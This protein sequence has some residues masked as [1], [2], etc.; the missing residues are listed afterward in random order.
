M[1]NPKK[2]VEVS[3]S[4]QNDN[5]YPRV[6]PRGHATLT[7]KEYISER[8]NPAIEWYDDE[9][10][11]L[12]KRYLFMRAITVIGGALVPVLVNLDIP[13]ID[14]LTT[15]ISLIVVLL[16]SL[17]SVYHYSAQWTN[18]RST[19]Q[20]LRKEY[21]LFVANEGP[22]A[23]NTD[24]VAYRL[25]VER[26]EMAIEAEVSTTLRVMTTVSET[27]SEGSIPQTASGQP[28]QPDVGS[29]PG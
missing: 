11:S 1:T 17:E 25:F 9:A 14:Y 24:D 3:Q 19:E 10:R 26:I 20:F 15:I 4:T 8:L 12:K 6:P 18:Y 21:F 23:G 13:Y 27:K 16:V 28:K 29:T 2:E 22:Y 7:P 5:L